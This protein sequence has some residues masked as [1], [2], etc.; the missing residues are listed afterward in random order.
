MSAAGWTRREFEARGLVRPLKSIAALFGFGFDDLFASR[1]EPVAHAA[2]M[3]QARRR[4]LDA[5]W[6]AWR[7]L[8]DRGWSYAEIGTAW[9][10]G[11]QTV[12]RAIGPD[13]DTWLAEHREATRRAS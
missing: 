11:H 9:G 12:R 6:T 10:V 4:R 1:Y 8:R 2:R 3:E 5:R 13:R 7:Y